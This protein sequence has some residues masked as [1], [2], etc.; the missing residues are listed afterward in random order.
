LCDILNDSGGGDDDDDIVVIIIVIINIHE[1]IIITVIMS[2][3]INTRETENTEL[4]FTVLY[5]VL[6]QTVSR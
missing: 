4:K 3:N 1:T 2:I 5:T 6:Y